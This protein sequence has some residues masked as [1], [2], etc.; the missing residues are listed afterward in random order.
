MSY[1][2]ASI[3][4]LRPRLVELAGRYRYAVS[5]FDQMA[6]SAFNFALNLCLVRALSANDFGIVSLWIAISGLAVGAQNALVNTPLSVYLPAEPDPQQ[7]RRLEEAIGIVNLIATSLSVLAVILTLV[8]ADA[9]WAPHDLLTLVAI[10]L[11]LAAGLYREYYRSMAFSRHDM[12]LLLWIDGPYLA[13]TSLALIA[14]VLFPAYFGTVAGAFLAMS[15]GCIA[16]R[17]IAGG[18]CRGPRLRPFRRGWL[19]AYRNILGEVTWS[20]VGV[21]AT[22][23]QTRG[24]VYA[25]VNLVGLTG[26]A[27]I[28]VV[29]VLFRPVRTMLTG[30]GRSALPNMAGLIARREFAAFD[31]AVGQAFVVAALASG[32]WFAILWLGWR[33]IE[34][35]FLAGKYPDAW[36][37]MWP[38]AIAAAVDSLEYVISVALQAMRQFKFLASIILVSAPLTVAATVVAILWHGYTW[39][40]YGVAFGGLVALILELGRVWVM[41]RRLTAAV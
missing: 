37:L 17:V 7:A 23:V 18:R 33:H 36:N 24:Y 11:A 13:V 15:I 32:A 9:E 35:H 39:A 21:G 25:T 8:A 2:L 16:S 4:R 28:N 19:A 26:L 34:V 38:W 22:H 10:P 3:D 6:L 41:R 30:W 27:A 14:I 40:M 29:G 1:G 20:L 31:R 12:A 5:A